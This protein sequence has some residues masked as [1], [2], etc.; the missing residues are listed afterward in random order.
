MTLSVVTGGTGFV[1][2]RLVQSLLARGD[3]VRVLDIAVPSPNDELVTG[4]VEF[5]KTD[6]TKADEVKKGVAGATTVFHV[7][8]VVHTKMNKLDF[9]F[10]VSGYNIP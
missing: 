7:A 10:K 9:V 6:I 2:R 1:G 4:K 5:I 8:S 3:R